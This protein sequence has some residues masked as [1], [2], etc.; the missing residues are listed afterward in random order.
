VW[1]D[2]EGEVRGLTFSPLY[3]AAATAA[4]RD[5]K[6]YELLTLV[7]AVRGGGARERTVALRLLEKRLQASDADD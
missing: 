6:L 7:D 2:P 1:P 3:K 5:P 4:R